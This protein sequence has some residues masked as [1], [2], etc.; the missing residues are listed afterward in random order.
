MAFDIRTLL[1]SVSLAAGCCAA[2]RIL[3]YRLHPSLPGLAQWAWS[4]AMGSAALALIASQDLLPPLL[5]QSVPLLLM[6]TASAAVWDGFRRFVGRPPVPARSFAIVAA[7]ALASMAAA[8]ATDRI[9]IQASCDTALLAIISAFS[10]RELLRAAPGTGTAMRATGWLAAANTPIFLLRAIAPLVG[11]APIG[12]TQSGPLSSFTLLYWLCATIA[13]TMGMVLMTGE[14]LQADLDR[15]AGSDPLTGALNRRAFAQLAERERARSRRTGLPSAVLMMDLDHFKKVNDRFGHATGDKVLVG[16]VATLRRVL[17]AQDVV[18]RFGGEEFLALLPDT[19]A[20][21]AYAVAERVRLAFSLD[22]ADLL[23]S[24]QCRELALTVSIGVGET[25]EEETIEATIQ[26]ADG[27]LYR[28]KA[29]GRNR[30]MPAETP[31]PQPV[32]AQ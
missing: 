9:V 11:L 2:A 4:G 16:F 27:A 22:A 29:E 13:L 6:V 18:C 14:R 10:S 32:P 23:S 3:L 12:P 19:G 5:T 17:R 1:V 25:R 31:Q 21:E 24:L 30:S 7:I 8:L 20:A 26:R 15:Q 28:A